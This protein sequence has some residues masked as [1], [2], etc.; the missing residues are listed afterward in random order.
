VLFKFLLVAEIV[1]QGSS[2]STRGLRFLSVLDVELTLGHAATPFD[3]SPLMMPA[4]SSPESTGSSLIHSNPRPP[5][6]DLWRLIVGPRLRCCAQEIVNTFDQVHGSKER[7]KT[8]HETCAPLALH[9]AA[10]ETPNA[11]AK[12]R[13]KD[14]ARPVAH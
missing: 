5:S 6:G 2:F 12:S 3:C 14:A 4:A 11:C 9:S 7:G 1:L 8:T 10:M 13:S